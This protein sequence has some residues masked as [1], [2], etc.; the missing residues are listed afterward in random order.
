MAQ[1]IRELLKQES[2]LPVE[3]LRAGHEKRFL[4]RLDESLPVRNKRSYTSWFN[5][6]ASIAILISISIFVYQPF[7]S[8]VVTNSTVSVDDNNTKDATIVL[9][10]E[11]SPLAKISPEYEKVENYLLTSIKFELSQIEKNDK[12]KEL[13]DSF[14]VRL[15]NLDAEYQRL[16]NELVEVGNVQSVEAMIE[17]LT[18][19]LDLLKRLKNKLKELETIGD[20][21]QYTEIH[22]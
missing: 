19:R 9:A 13:I 11:S 6:A 15:S 20:D 21:G 22:A 7:Q 17:N 18:L 3:P 14:M 1:D 16:N 5:M 4:D 12:N 8:D 2:K 10:K